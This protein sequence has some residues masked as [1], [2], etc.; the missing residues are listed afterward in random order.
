MNEYEYCR[1]QGVATNQPNRECC[2]QNITILSG[3]APTISSYSGP[4]SGSNGGN[5]WIEVIVTT[6]ISA[7]ITKV[8]TVATVR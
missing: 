5:G 6:S 7:V 4:P 1:R 2:H 3:A 8:E